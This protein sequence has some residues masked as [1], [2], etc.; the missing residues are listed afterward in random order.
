MI[1][2]KYVTVREFN[3]ETLNGTLVK[4]KE[5]FEYWAS[6][7]WKKPFK[8]L[9]LLFKL[10]VKNEQIKRHWMAKNI[11][12]IYNWHRRERNCR[13]SDKQMTYSCTK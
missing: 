7:Y 10:S 8:E 2:R 5:Q 1:G 3:A 4:T 9:N 11:Q 6:L 12:G 13:A